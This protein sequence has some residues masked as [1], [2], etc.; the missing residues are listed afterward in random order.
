M[1]R[2]DQR[3]PRLLAVRGLVLLFLLVVL[4]F[5]L[6]WGAAAT[7]C[8]HEKSPASGHFGHHSHQHQ[9][10]AMAESDSGSTVKKASVPAD[11]P[12]CGVCHLC[13]VPPP[14]SQATS[15]GAIVAAALVPP[16]ALPA[17]PGRPGRIERPKWSP[18]A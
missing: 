6:A 12:D 18:V 14:S 3:C 11:D 7:Y 5:Q 16:T 13:C 2:L 8:G 10:K 9:A 17:C 1:L 15:I 4:P